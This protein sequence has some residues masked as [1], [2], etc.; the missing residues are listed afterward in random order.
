MFFFNILRQLVFDFFRE[1]LRNQKNCYFQSKIILHLI[2]QS[3][4]IDIK[5]VKRYIYI[6]VTPFR[7]EK[8]VFETFNYVIHYKNA[9]RVPSENC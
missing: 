7:T 1:K 4:C 8:N 3:I 2:R 9:V 6:K 5:D